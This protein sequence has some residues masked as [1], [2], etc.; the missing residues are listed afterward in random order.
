[1]FGCKFG[2]GEACL[3]LLFLLLLQSLDLGLEQ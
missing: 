1:M 3:T 2:I